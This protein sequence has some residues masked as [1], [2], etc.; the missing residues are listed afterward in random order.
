MLEEAEEENDPIGK[1]AVSTNLIPGISETL[2]HLIIG[3]LSQLI[4]GL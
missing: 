4:W 3:S 1:S 2:S